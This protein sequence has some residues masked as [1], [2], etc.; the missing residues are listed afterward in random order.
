ML[1]LV[2]GEGAGQ[3]E[4]PGLRTCV[5]A[6]REIE[7]HQV[8][9]P[10]PGVALDAEEGVPADDDGERAPSQLRGGAGPEPGRV[11]DARR[12]D[13]LARGG[14]DSPCPPAGRTYRHHL[15]SLLDANAAASRR[16]GVP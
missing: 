4:A 12:L 5:A 14:L 9:W 8:R 15:D 7:V 6:A 10:E 16:L 11:D 2:V 1:R 13:A 3:R